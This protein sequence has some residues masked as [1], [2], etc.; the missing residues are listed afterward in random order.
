MKRAPFTHFSASGVAVAGPGPSRSAS[1]PTCPRTQGATRW[2]NC[3]R[4]RRASARTYARVVATAARRFPGGAGAGRG[5]V[6]AGAAGGGAR[7]PAAPPEP[8]AGRGAAAQGGGRE[9]LAPTIAEAHGQDGD[10]RQ[11][12]R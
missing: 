2:Q 3:F 6:P 11:S 5:L 1:V 7:E 8:A 4:S 12:E 9:R 10:E